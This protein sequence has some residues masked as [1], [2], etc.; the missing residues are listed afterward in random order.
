VHVA[1]GL[2]CL[3]FTHEQVA[4]EAGHVRSILAAV[5]RRP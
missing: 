3:R 1:S 5:T 2:T 4:S